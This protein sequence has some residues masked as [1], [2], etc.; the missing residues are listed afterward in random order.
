M[1]ILH[2]NLYRKY[3][4]AIV[5]GTKT[6]EYR[7]KTDYWKKYSLLY[8]SKI[9]FDVN[10]IQ[11]EVEKKVSLN[12]RKVNKIYKWKAEYNINQALIECI[13]E[14]KKILKI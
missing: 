14:A 4:D 11:K 8:N 1:K 6:I 13:N 12:L 7:K 10:L 5:E 9:N 2:L 3:F